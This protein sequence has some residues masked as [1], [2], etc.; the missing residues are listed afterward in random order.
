MLAGWRVETEAKIIQNERRE[1]NKKEANIE[2][3]RNI[4][5]SEES[6]GV[7]GRGEDHH[8]EPPHGDQNHYSTGMQLHIF[9]F[10]SYLFLFYIL[11]LIL[12]FILLFICSK[13]GCSY[14]DGR[15][16]SR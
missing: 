12:L 3:S 6:K 15:G 5:I 1:Q 2:Y 13:L 4:F 7:R 9:S 14:T 10:V 16:R 11:L 8:Q